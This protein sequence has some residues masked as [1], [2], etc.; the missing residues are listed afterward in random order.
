MLAVSEQHVCKVVVAAVDGSVG[1]EADHATQSSVDNGLGVDAV[2]CC[3]VVV[4]GC[5][6]CFPLRLERLACISCSSLLLRRC[7]TISLRKR[8]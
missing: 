7:K 8:K 5:P 4:G 2:I 3:M 6:W 1:Q